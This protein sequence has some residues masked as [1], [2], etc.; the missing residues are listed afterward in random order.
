MAARIG[1]LGVGLHLPPE[2]RRND[3]WAPELV[4]KWAEQRRASPR[5][6]PTPKTPGAERVLAAMRQQAADPFQGGEIRHVLAPDLDITDME[7]AAAREALADAKLRPD[8]I[9][10][11]L[12]F[13]IVPEYLLSNPGCVLHARLGMPRE[14]FTMQADAAAYSF[15]GQLALAESMILA[16]RARRALLVQSSTATRL[17][18]LEDPQSVLVGDGAT[19]V[20]VGLVPETRGIEASVMFTDGRYPK[21][22]IGSVR[23]GSWYDAGRAQMHVANWDQMND[24]FLSTA[25]VCKDSVD[26][27]I[28]RAG[29]SLRDVDFLCTY[30]GTPWLGRVVQEYA[31]LE[32]A[33]SHDTYPELGY[34]SAAMVP[35]NLY[36]ARQRGHLRDG[37]L[38]LMTGGG[39]GMTYGATLLRWG[40]A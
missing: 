17:I 29:R 40:A 15:L 26:A 1:I 10:L 20:V 22:V 34:L 11:V 38:V 7:E 9:D 39:T 18:D 3:T 6:L 36:L 33:R 37:D 25:D 8:D 13:A 28:A 32:H 35:A 12:S 27:V 30:Q 24:V 16:G 14:C 2:I 5:T 23:G 21:S 31:G 19:A 4:A